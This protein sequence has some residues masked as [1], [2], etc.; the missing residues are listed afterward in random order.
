MPGRN[1]S[2]SRR[3]KDTLWV[4]VAATLIL[5]AGIGAVMGRW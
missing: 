3:I 5:G 4:L 2:F 1:N